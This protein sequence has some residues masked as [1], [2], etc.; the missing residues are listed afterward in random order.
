MPLKLS[1]ESQFIQKGEMG[2]AIQVKR[3]QYSTMLEKRLG[4]GT[5]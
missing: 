5:N 2:Y 4:H 3:E 1:F